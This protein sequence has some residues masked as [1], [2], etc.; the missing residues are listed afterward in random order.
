MGLVLQPVAIA[1]AHAKGPSVFVQCDGSP[2]RASTLG[3]VARLIAITAVIGLLIPPREAANAELRLEGQAGID[4]CNRALSPEEGAKDGGRRIE[5]ILGRAIHRMEIQDWDGALADIE[6]VAVDQPELVKTRAYFDSLGLT[7][8]NL[9]AMA[10]VGKG[11]LDAAR[12]TA[13]E[14]GLVLPYNRIAVGNAARYLLLG[15]EYDA[16]TERVIDQYVRLKTEA[17]PVRAGMLAVAGR[18]GDAARDYEAYG[19]IAATMLAETDISYLQVASIGHRLA[20]DVEM[21]K[22][23]LAEADRRMAVMPKDKLYNTTNDVAN[24]VRDFVTIIDKFEAGQVELARAL[25]AARSKWTYVLDGYVVEMS[26]RLD[27]AA[28]ADLKVKFPIKDVDTLLAERV[29]EMRIA[30]EDVGKGSKDRWQLFYPAVSENEYKRFSKNVWAT[31]KKRY[32]QKKEE[33]EL[34]AMYVTTSRDG[35]GF[36]GGYAFYLYNALVAKSMG[37]KGF[38]VLPFQEYVF[39][40]F[41]RYGN[42]GDPLIADAA[43]F[44]ADTVI[45]DLSP[46][47]PR[48]V[49]K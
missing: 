19:R 6:S 23:Q 7:A 42:P 17:L 18:F 4:A 43:L 14:M 48:P 28:D 35:G 36:P 3:T 27:A 21:S 22:A 41:V 37:K 11:E 26:R 44:D 8:R 45:A 1:P 46:L 29:T 12:E 15:T 32:S 9:K 5:L 25:F 34:Q 31:D 47:I 2:N 49:K 24:E 39:Q 38:M 20:G 33:A 30:I 10:L 40:H 16:Q 13:K